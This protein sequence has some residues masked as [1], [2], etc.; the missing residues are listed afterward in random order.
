MKTITAE[1]SSAVGT[2]N[3]LFTTTLA[4]VHAEKRRNCK[5][6]KNVNL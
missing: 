3:L 1:V 6:I 4:S 2:R 5:E